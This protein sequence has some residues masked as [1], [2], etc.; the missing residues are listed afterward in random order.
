MEFV[1]TIIMMSPIFIISIVIKFFFFYI[2]ICVG[3]HFKIDIYYFSLCYFLNSFYLS[4]KSNNFSKS[5]Y[6]YFCFV[7]YLV[8][9]CF[10]V[11]IVSC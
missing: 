7:I 4:F 11:N 3:D 6:I 10:F 2:L 1:L 8:F 9:D 5:A